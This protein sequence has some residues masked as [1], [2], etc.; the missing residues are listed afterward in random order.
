MITCLSVQFKRSISGALVASLIWSL[1]LIYITYSSTD[2]SHVNYMTMD[3]MMMGQKNYLHLYHDVM[4]KAASIAT[5][6][7]EETKKTTTTTVPKQNKLPQL[8]MKKPPS[9][10]L[11]WLARK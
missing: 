11:V 8:K 5:D 7:S 3:H 2:T 10:T 4:R 9:L 1:A 6:L